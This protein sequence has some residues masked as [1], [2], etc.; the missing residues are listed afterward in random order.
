MKKCRVA[1]NALNKSKT[2]HKTIDRV[3]GNE[4]D[5]RFH[6]SKYIYVAHPIH[7]SNEILR[8]T[9]AQFKSEKL[10]RIARTLKFISG[11]VYLGRSFNF[12]QRSKQQLDVQYRSK[13]FLA[14]SQIVGPKDVLL[15]AY[16]YPL[17][18]KSINIDIMETILIWTLRAMQPLKRQT[19]NFAAEQIVK[20][21]EGWMGNHCDSQ[22]VNDSP[23]ENID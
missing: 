16:R 5:R 4:K 20:H 15:S 14:N 12:D 13:S 1:W 3:S 18:K 22:F 11:S 6:M 23:C 2:F 17:C 8:L 21:Y 19:Y 10:G 7:Q 9:D